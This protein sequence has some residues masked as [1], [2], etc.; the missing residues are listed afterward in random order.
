[1]DQ[2][3]VTCTVEGD[4]VIVSLPLKGAKAIGL[5]VEAVMDTAVYVSAEDIGVTRGEQAAAIKSLSDLHIELSN[6]EGAD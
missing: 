5:I 1:M 4:R 3:S 2:N 6:L